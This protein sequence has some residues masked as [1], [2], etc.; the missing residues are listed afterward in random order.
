MA[1][2]PWHTVVTPREDL[3]ENRP[4]DASEFAVHLDHVR[5]GRAPEDYTDPKRFFDRTYL[6]KTLLELAAGVAR[7]LSGIRVE[8]S[9]VYNLT[10]AFGGG[11]THAL[12]L[13]FHLARGGPKAS[14]WKDV[15]R[16][17]KAADV[18]SMPAAE[19][20]VF[21][22]HE[23]DSLTGRQDHPDE[24]RRKTPWGEIAFQLGGAKA[25]AVVEEHDRTGIAPS[26]E[27]IRQFLPKNKPSLILMD[28][29]MNYVS[30]YRDNGLGT[31]LYNFVHNLSEEVRGQENVVLAVSL[32]AS[33][34]E[35]SAQDHGD[36]DRLKK[37][38]ERVGKGVVLSAGHETSEIIRRRLFDWNGL[39]PEAEATAKAY[40]DF[41]IANRASF[42]AFAVDSAEET[43]R[44]TYP[45]H[46]T[47]LS[48]FERKW[49]ALPQ[50]QRTRGVLRMLALWV[51]HAFTVDH[52]KAHKDPLIMLGTAPLADPLFRRAIFGQLGEDRLEAA[53]TTDIAGKKDANA[54]RLD[55]EASD[56]IKKARL[57]QKVAT[58]IFFESN[59]GQNKA[60]ATQP[61]IKVDVAEPDLDI[62]NVDTVI[63]ALVEDCYY[64]SPDG[65]R[66]HF[67]HKPNLNRLVADR[68]ATVD[69]KR[70]AARIRAE[71]EK[72]FTLPKGSGA[73]LV[74]FPEDSASIADRAMLTVVVLPPDLTLK[75]KAALDF[76]ESATRERG[77]SGRTFKTALLWVIA[78]GPDRLREEASKLLAWEAIDYEAEDLKL[79]DSQK[80]HLATSLKS[81]ARDLKEAVWRTYKNVRFLGKNGTLRDVDLG[82]NNSSQADSIVSIVLQ[83]LK[84]DHVIT[85]DVTPTM[86]TR[87]WADA[88]QE[89]STKSVREAFFSSPEFP[90]LLNQ[91]VGKDVVKETIAKG[92]SSG[93]L[94]YVGKK[95]GTYDPFFFGVALSASDIEISDEMFIIQKEVAEAF[96]AGKEVKTARSVPPPTGPKVEPEATPEEKA[97]PQLDL[98]R[99]T[100]PPPKLTRLV[101]KGDVPP[102]KWMNFYTKVL[103]RFATASGLK[104]T[105]R[106]EIAPSG[107]ISTQ[108][109]D[110]MKVAL[111]D[112]G[113]NDD[114]ECE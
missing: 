16:I 59:G 80:K 36:Y 21:V 22:G 110:E 93:L 61:E 109:A 79:E 24:P 85:D 108:A 64:L 11:K 44:A 96:K 43:I 107:G 8:T 51:G 90:R 29:L 9:P 15:E 92:V 86:L 32:P 98:I 12:S 87:H 18:A 14:G 2:K 30:R 68:R 47:V 78:D 31:Q 94:G 28:E 35:M 27:V 74:L 101:W 89:W 39:P 52:R 40:A 62:A 112:L 34:L 38:V 88:F 42:G 76:I 84:N 69:A 113:L 45:F 103:S 77:A 104:L 72:S 100:P 106:V 82:Q 19:T 75:D 53:V 66:Y 55:K 60:V 105:L 67:S 6:T 91:D 23:F 5:L 37:L 54:I 102:Q 10:T 13:L 71:V 56:A 25:F 63:E 57:H 95:N 50:F 111:R 41:L 114:F 26:S 81:A 20:A 83:R 33:E 7:R 17:L 49:Q 3:R 70:V 65:N 97:K 1:L 58:T 4:L 99:K 46:P 73:S 48:V